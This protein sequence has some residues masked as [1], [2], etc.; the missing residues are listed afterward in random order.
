MTMSG[1]QTL[2]SGDVLL[3][4]SDGLWAGLTD[5]QIASL[6]RDPKRHLRDALA[7]IGARAVQTTS[8][9]A[10]NTTAAAVRWLKDAPHEVAH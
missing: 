10:D 7:D 2:R 5:G 3:L 9:F 8:P 4:C 1:R 6:T